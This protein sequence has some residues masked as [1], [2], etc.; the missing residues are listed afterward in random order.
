MKKNLYITYTL[1]AGLA[2]SSCKKSY[3]D[4]LPARSIESNESF[5]SPSRVNAAM[6]GLYDLMQQNQFTNHIML[7]TDVKG[8]DLLVVSSGNYNRFVTEY[9]FTEIANGGTGALSFV[10]WKRAFEMISNC[11]QAISKLPTSPVADD[12]KND[13]MAEARVLRAWANHQ[14][15]RL[16]AQPY[17]VNPDGIGIPKVDKPLKKDDPTPA[18]SSVK[19]IYAFMLEDLK[20]AEQNLSAKRSNSYRITI[21]AV[22]ALQARL[23]LDMGKW[24]EASSYAKKARAGFSLEPGATLLKGFVDKTPEWIWGLNYRTDDNTGFLMLASFQ[25]PYNLGYSTF[26][27]SKSFLTLFGDDDIRKKQFF[28]NEAKVKSGK[29]EDEALQRDKIMFSRDGYL[30]NKF[31]FRKTLDL[32]LPLI[33]SAEM[34]LIEAEAE[35]ELNNTDAAQTALFEVQRRAIPTAVKSINTGDVLKTEIVNER[36]KELY[37]EGFRFF[38]ILRRKETLVR[39]AADHWKPLTQEPGNN[40]NVLPIPQRELDISHL[41]QNKGYN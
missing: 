32:D 12:V 20:F 14:L 6:I 3:L 15:V 40:R 28:V 35:A 10:F 21:N 33:R 37:G 13:Y 30:M 18:R 26:R 16:Y 39:A 4:T 31:Y 19:D 11:N 7:T 36:R 34:Y 17:A 41:E 8:G 24:T 27:A 38:D 25:E 22:Y 23:Y 5:T 1:V 29:A 2:F 9:Q